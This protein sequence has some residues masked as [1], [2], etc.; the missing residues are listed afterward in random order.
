[1]MMSLSSEASTLA[2]PAGSTA[3]WANDKFFTINLNTT[4]FYDLNLRF[5]ARTAANPTPHE[6]APSS[7]LVS[8]RIGDGDW[9]DTLLPASW[10]A[11]GSYHEVAVDFSD[12]TD[13]NDQSSVDIRFT[14]ADGPSS[15]PTEN[16]TRNVRVDNLLITAVPEPSTA[17]LASAALLALAIR[18][19]RRG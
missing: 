7:Y 17:F 11:N 3:A 19:N 1:M 6:Q 14:L 12:Y 15:A 2:P 16:T 8:Y 13:I 9:T 4:G 5:D 10:T 18:R